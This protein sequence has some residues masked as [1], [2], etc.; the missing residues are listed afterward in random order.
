MLTIGCDTDLKKSTVYFIIF[1]LA[2]SDI[3]ISI[4]GSKNGVSSI[5]CQRGAALAFA[6]AKDTTL[7]TWLRSWKYSSSAGVM[8]L[9]LKLSFEYVLLVDTRTLCILISSNSFTTWIVASFQYISIMDSYDSYDFD[10]CSTMDSYDC[11]WF[12][13]LWMST[14]DS[15]NFNWFLHRCIGFQFISII[16]S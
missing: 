6:W 13:V 16:S 7:V 11:K 8:T 14:M 2:L 10:W 3:I 5:G 1:S 15:Y 9:C 4:F 12:L